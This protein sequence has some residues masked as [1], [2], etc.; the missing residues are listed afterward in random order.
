MNDVRGVPVSGADDAALA[1]FEAALLSYQTFV[2]DPVA[3]I[4]QVLERKPDFILGHLMRAGVLMTASERRVLPEAR[5]SLA[6]ADA[7]AGGANDR[8]KGLTAAI[9]H[10]VDGDWHR[11]CAGFDSVLA[12][13]P[14]D[15]FALQTAHLFD[16]Y[17]GDA[18]NLRNRVSRVLPDWDS[19]VPNYSYLLGMQAF[20]FEE[21]NQYPEAEAAGRRA[22]ELQRRDAWAVHAVTHVMEMTGRIDEGIAWLESRRPDWA[23]DNGF[24]FH[25]FWHLAL[26]R[27]DTAD[28]DAALDLYDNNVYP[29]AL[30]VCLVMVDAAALLWRLYLEGA[31]LEDR[32]NALAAV[33]AR[34]IDAEEGYYAFNDL[35]AVMAFCI[36]GRFDRARDLIDHLEHLARAPRGTNGVMN[37]EVGLPLARAMLAFAQG[38]YA[39]AIACALPVRDR[40]YTFGGSHAQRDVVTLTLIEAALRGGQHNL[41][42]HLIAERTVHKPAS[43]WGWRLFDRANG[44]SRQH[45]V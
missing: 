30:D 22:L 1:G 27:L 31:P 33:W 39:A 4:E 17:R 8:E 9:R 6:A 7:L 18:L 19:A 14:R 15:V 35:H 38:N 43:A 36:A 10:L 32:P 11:A 20:G 3:T 44:R 21:C 40:A 16:F 28:Y 26:Y 45:I 13:H 42:R 2:G 25:N 34:R 37:A 12:D 24:A 41:A 23:P 29:S 5:K